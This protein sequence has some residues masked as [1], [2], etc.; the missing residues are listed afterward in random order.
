MKYL[1]YII[2]LLIFMSL[3]FLSRKNDKKQEIK[4]A[5][6]LHNGIKFTGKVTGIKTSQNHAF[7]IILLEL[8]NT[9]TP[10]FTKSTSTIEFPY[11][12]FGDNAEL[13]TRVP[14]GLTVG[15]LVSVNSDLVT[16]TYFYVAEKE[17]H[18][19]FINIIH[20]S[21]DI[22]FIHENKIAANSK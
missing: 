7:G 16:A 17:P 14:D 19:G 10:K 6:L 18:E 3:V 21:T 13:Y 9:N 2:L 15:D 20:D 5:H 1:K 11:K 4:D 22:E 12:I 8:K